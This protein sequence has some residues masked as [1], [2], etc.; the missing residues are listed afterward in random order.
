MKGNLVSRKINSLET[1]ITTGIFQTS[2]TFK[3]KTLIFH[4]KLK[5]FNKNNYQPLDMK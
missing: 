5:I 3:V 1:M 2:N 4:V